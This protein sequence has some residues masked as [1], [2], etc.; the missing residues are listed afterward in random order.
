L[1]A[2]ALITTAC[3]DDSDDGDTRADS[4]AITAQGTTGPTGTTAQQGSSG[5]RSSNGSEKGSSKK[6]KSGSHESD[7][8][9]RQPSPSGKV[10]KGEG[11][12][13][14]QPQGPLPEAAKAFVEEQQ[15]L[16]KYLRREL[17]AYRRQIQGVEVGGGKLTLVTNLLG[18]P[19]GAKTARLLCDKVAG[20]DRDRF[21]GHIQVRGAGSAILARC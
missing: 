6:N 19:E 21:G 16:R 20:Y 10:E 2:A 1:C 14:I 13:E 7:E 18:D 15:E 5:S 12:D 11:S 3:G 8:K 4:Q 17:G 9:K